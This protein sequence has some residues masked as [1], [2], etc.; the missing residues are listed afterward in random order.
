MVS[1]LARNFS[2]GYMAQQFHVAYSSLVSGVGV[3]AGAPY[4]WTSKRVGRSRLRPSSGA[5]DLA[6]KPG[7]ATRIM[8]STCALIVQRAR[9]VHRRR[10]RDERTLP[11]SREAQ[12]ARRPG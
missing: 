7:I 4:T 11:N 8:G 3:L 9:Y 10:A 12:P 2:G 1:S 5:M 6:R